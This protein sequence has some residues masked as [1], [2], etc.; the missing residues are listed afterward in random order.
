MK[1]DEYKKRKKKAYKRKIFISIVCGT[2]IAGTG[3]TV[4]YFI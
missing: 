2:L 4:G 3:L 1:I